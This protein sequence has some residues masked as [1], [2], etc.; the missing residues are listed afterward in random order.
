VGLGDDFF[1]LGGH[2]L[3]AARVVARVRERLGVQVALGEF[4]RVP[5]LAELA[6][7]LDSSARGATAAPIP[8]LPGD[9]PFPL[10]PAQRRLWLWEQ[11][12]PGRAAYNVPVALRLR[13][14]LDAA[15]VERALAALVG[16]H[17]ALR[18]VFDA[19]DGDP[20]QRFLPES[21]FALA[22][23]ALPAG[24]DPEEAVRRRLAAEAARPF[25]LAA[26]PLLR[27]LLLC[28]GDDEHVLLLTVHHLVC[29]GWSLGILLRELSALYEAFSR[30]EPPPLPALAL[31]YA[32]YALWHRERL[33]A[34]EEAQLAWWRERLAGAPAL[35]ELP[36]DRP[37]PA[38][39]THRGAQ[40]P[41]RL[42]AALV[43][44]A[45]ALGREEGATLHMVLLAAFG[46]VLAR[47]AR[48]D[49]VL[50]GSASAGR[51]HPDT[52]ALVGF[53]V[54]LVP[55]RA[56]LSGDPEFRAI[57]RQVRERA[58]EAYDHQDVP[59]DRLVE[60]LAPERGRGHSPLVQ[61]AFAFQDAPAR[62]F[63]LGAARGEAEPVDPGTAQFD[64]NFFLDEGDGGVAGGLEYA[65]DLFDAAT[66]E[67]IGTRIRVL[68]EAAVAVPERRVSVLPLLG[69]GERER[70]LGWSGAGESFPVLGGLH[71]RFEA[72][73]A[74]R[75]G[76]A[77]VSYEGE[78]L[79]YGELNAR[80]NRLARRLRALGVAPESRVGLCAERSLDLVAGVLA[81]VKAGGAYVPL[82]PAYP[83]ERLAHMAEDSGIRV[84]VAQPAL[85]DRVPVD[86][87]EIV[88][89]DE[90]PIDEIADDLDVSVSPE[91][92]AYV[93][94]TSGSTGRPKGVG[95]THGNVLR[96]FD[97]TRPS[98]AFGD[99][100]VW[101]LF[102]S[103]AFDFSVW[104]MW[105]ALLHGGRLAVVPRPVA[106]D[107]AAFR[108][109]LA[110]ERVTVLSQTPSAFR[111]LAAVDEGEA[112][113]LER[114]RA[115]VFGGEALRYE[116]LRGWL[117]RYGP[118]GPR[119]VN[120]YGITETTVHVTWHAVT[121]A[122]VGDPRAGSGVGVP[123]ADLR[124]YVLDPA[125]RPAPVGVPGELYV[126]GAGV[127][128]GYLGRPGLT[129]E[130]F[131]PD[132]FASV[133]GARMYRT[134][135]R[136]R[137]T[138]SALVRECV[139]ALAGEPQGA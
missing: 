53:F 49:E 101:T 23:E 75:P 62:G 129:A 89:L 66:A 11:M 85:R 22:V 28:A 51:T 67:R 72:R 83:A 115:V 40:H 69:E 48:A 78:S 109:L 25:D 29:D 61:V 26:G 103:Y 137:W 86:G 117:D 27:A 34:V 60:E 68:L 118:A 102:H 94:Y 36:T 30:G 64:L 127:A 80:A 19:R 92:L 13:G 98:F 123:I 70:V 2:S 42:P 52:E 76:A 91:N 82:D 50:V 31:R 119:L 87:I 20:V 93:I 71:Q 1:A 134:G 97:C 106:R 120:M 38:V 6:K 135:D 124:A 99:S 73:A 9:G 77:A 74:A 5:T 132:P 139:S 100:D 126:G 79:S 113:P 14:P 35:L 121:G 39:Q 47:H 107:P 133:P 111:A 59:F 10:A 4:F 41:V 110:R 104:E 58:L 88:S 81:I 7:A 90:V 112:E 128:R 32:D 96:L 8:R 105:G 54:S 136:V 16:R 138:E 57:V 17:G 125:G 33:A 21:P 55:V 15:V 130:R 108:E 122:E 45:R 18:T 12:N 84:L 114:L 95:V 37:R 65:S 24:G 116:S 43:E 131:V 56:D 46:V 3:A 44:R 63:R